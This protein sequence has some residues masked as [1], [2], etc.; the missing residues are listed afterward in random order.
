MESVKF[1]EWINRE[2]KWHTRQ[3]RNLTQLITKVFRSKQF[4]KK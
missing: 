4:K 3:S 1:S 2:T